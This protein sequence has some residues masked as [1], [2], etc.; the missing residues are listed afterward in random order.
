MGWLSGAPVT[1]LLG[2]GVIVE[3]SGPDPRFLERGFKC[4]KGGSFCHFYIDFLKNPHEIEILWPQRG[5]KR[6]P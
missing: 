6:T 5:F 2:M 4:K 3:V 1:E